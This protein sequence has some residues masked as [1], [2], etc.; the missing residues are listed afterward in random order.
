MR[1]WIATGVASVTLAFSCASA[2]ATWKVV[3]STGPSGAKAS[4]LYG[5]SC[6]TGE[7]CRVV[8]D[9]ITSGGVQK[10]LAARLGV[11]VEFPPNPGGTEPALYNVSCPL[12]AHETFCMAVGSYEE[13]GVPIALAEKWTSSGGWEL[14]KLPFP[15]GNT[16]SQLG[17]VSC[18]SSSECMATGDYH[19]ST[20]EHNLAEHW[21]S[22]GGWT[23]EVPAM[24][25]GAGYPAFNSVSCPETEKCLAVGDYRNSLGV[26]ADGVG[27]VEWRLVGDLDR[28]ESPHGRHRHGRSQRLVRDAQR[29]HGGRLLYN[30]RQNLDH[31][32]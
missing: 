27:Q 7:S 12:S 21:T 25:S 22:S 3:S 30:K 16:A 29:M 20:G 11:E 23:A 2:S 17:G 1:W 5:I 19:D 13:G 24:V 14:Q 6:G 31:G 15:A 28:D 4:R 9:Y 32:R 26:E 18:H 10:T 8:G